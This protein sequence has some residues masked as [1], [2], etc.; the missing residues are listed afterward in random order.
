MYLFADSCRSSRLQEGKAATYAYLKDQAQPHFLAFIFGG[1][2][3]DLRTT[4]VIVGSIFST[5]SVKYQ[6]RTLLR[7][8]SARISNATALCRKKRNRPSSFELLVMVFT[9]D[10]GVD[11]QLIHADEFQNLDIVNT[12]NAR[13]YNMECLRAGVKLDRFGY[14]ELSMRQSVCREGKM[15]ILTSYLRLMKY[16]GYLNK[17]PRLL[18][19]R[20]AM[21]IVQKVKVSMCCYALYHSSLDDIWKDW[22]R[23]QGNKCFERFQSLFQT[24]HIITSGWNEVRRLLS[25]APDL[26]QD[27]KRFFP[28][29]WLHYRDSYAKCCSTCLF[30]GCSQVI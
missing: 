18:D 14:S 17:I 6:L 27:K 19:M 22:S 5:P 20:D 16:E 30:P 11:L 8:I 4:S 25:L 15:L 24:V 28:D 7:L 10:A 23:T 9:T 21:T 3:Q 13:I 2:L 12:L 29:F 26:E 1:G